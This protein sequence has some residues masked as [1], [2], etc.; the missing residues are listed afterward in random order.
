[1][2]PPGPGRLPESRCRRAAPSSPSSD[3]HCSKRLLSATVER[4]RAVSMFATDQQDA[5][6]IDMIAAVS[7]SPSPGSMPVRARSIVARRS[8]CGAVRAAGRGE[9]QTNNGGAPN[10]WEGLLHAHSRFR[11]KARNR[12]CQ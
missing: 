7:V 4:Q 8:R 10:S 5:P 9:S 2:R 6:S 3:S 11:M 12:S 1:M